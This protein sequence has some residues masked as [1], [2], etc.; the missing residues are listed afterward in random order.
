L[1]VRPA[2]QPQIRDRGLPAAR[3]RLDVIE[4][5]LPARFATP[6][7]PGDERAAIAVASADLALYFGRDVAAL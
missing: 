2:A 4:L 1:I 6:A 3:D 7:T 5:Q